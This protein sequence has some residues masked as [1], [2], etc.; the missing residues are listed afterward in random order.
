[1]RPSWWVLTQYDWCP[2]KKRGLGDRCRAGPPCEDA[3]ETALMHPKERP[4]ETTLPAPVSPSA[5]LRISVSG[6]SLSTWSSVAGP[7]C[8]LSRF[9]RLQAGALEMVVLWRGVLSTPGAA[10]LCLLWLSDSTEPMFLV[11]GT[12]GSGLS[13]FSPSFQLSSSNVDWSPSRLMGG[14]VLSHATHVGPQEPIGTFCGWQAL[15]DSIQT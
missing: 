14:P 1:M 13:A 6:L 5:G 12:S 4:R 8:G 7:S 3:E 15:F 9:D 2:F 10:P 11:T